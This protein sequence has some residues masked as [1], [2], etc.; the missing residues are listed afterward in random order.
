M[1]GR[2]EGGKWRWI[3]VWVGERRLRSLK[4]TL[5]CFTVLGTEQ[6]LQS[7]G[8][9]SS[10]YDLPVS[11]TAPISISCDLLISMTII[12]VETFYVE[13]CKT[14][15]LIQGHREPQ[16]NEHSVRSMH[17]CDILH[18]FILLGC[19]GEGWYL[20][21]IWLSHS[22]MKLPPQYMHCYSTLLYCTLALFYSDTLPCLVSLGMECA[23][24]VLFEA[25]LD[26]AKSGE[27]EWTICDIDDWL[28]GNEFWNFSKIKM[29]K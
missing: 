5:R 20:H 18:V 29:A 8:R 1:K 3:S 7:C 22:A 26:S 11:T 2:R 6:Y 13:D 16:H 27:I 28:E 19:D 9:H 14:N 12:C 21:S 17:M 25:V 4:W 23:I 15:T 24:Q 10:A